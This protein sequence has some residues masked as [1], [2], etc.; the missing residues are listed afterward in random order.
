MNNSLKREKK[1]TGYFFAVAKRERE[2]T[3]SV[4]KMTVST[5]ELQSEKVA[6]PLLPPFYPLFLLQA[7]PSSWI[8]RIIMK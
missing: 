7:M 6:C 2:A 5:H 8:M 4:V 3:F 1:G